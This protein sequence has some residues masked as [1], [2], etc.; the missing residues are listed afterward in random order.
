MTYCIG[1]RTKSAAFL[2]ADAAATTRGGALRGTRSTFGELHVSE[3]GRCVEETSLKLYR[4]HNLGMT[5]SGDAAT[6][7]QFARLVHRHLGRGFPEIA[8]L[9]AAL[10]EIKR[11]SERR[12]EAL[13]ATSLCGRPRLFRLDGDGAWH[14]VPR[15]H[16]VHLGSPSNRFKE[17]VHQVISEVLHD[18]LP[19][20]AQ[21]VC[22]LAACQSLTVHEYLMAEG[23]GGAFT[24]LIAERNGVRWQPDLAYILLNPSDVRRIDQPPVPSRETNLISC[25][26]RDDV[27]FVASPHSRGTI[28]FLSPTTDTADAEMIERARAAYPSAALVRGEATFAYV[29][30]ISR[31]KPIVA[32]VQTKGRAASPH[33]RL[34][35]VPAGDVEAFEVRA[36]KMLHSVMTGEGPGFDR[37]RLIYCAD[38]AEPTRGLGT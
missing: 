22:A 3:R 15:M 21:L 36:S 32:V 8:A 9:Q 23:A 29:A 13:F 12:F 26:V 31:Q 10:E 5:A 16:A 35:R 6:I 19:T 2:I 38:T 18:R 33:L 17:F 4:W 25:V 20:D 24:G 37:P 14:Y 11:L 28:A 34:S 27:L 7:R 1:W 30:T